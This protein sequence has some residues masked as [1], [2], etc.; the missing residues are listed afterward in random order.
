MIRDFLKHNWPRYLYGSIF[1]ILVDLLMLVT[2]RVIGMIVDEIRGGAQDLNLVG[3]LILAVIGVAFGLFI[4][5]LLWRIFIMG[6]A[7]RFEYYTR[8]TLFEKLLTLSP[9]FYDKTRVGDLMARFTNDVN[10]V[11]MAMGPAIVMIIDAVFLVT[12]TIIAMGLFTNWSL[13]WISIAPLPALAV[14]STFFGKMIHK[15]F[16]LVQ[17]SFSDLTDTIEESISGV[18]LIKSYG[19][20]DLRNETLTEKSNLYV[21]KNMNLVKVWGMFFPLTQTLSMLGSVLATLFGGRMVIL[22]QITLGEYITFTSYL[23]MLVWPMTAFGWVINIIQRGRASYRRLMEVL[24]E[25]NNITTNDPIEV[26]SFEGH[27]VMKN[28]TFTYPT[29]TRPALENIDFEVKPDSKIAIVGTTGSGKSTMAKL[30]AR[31]YPVEEGMLFIDGVDINNLRPEAIRDNVAYVPQETFLFSETV[32]NNIRFGNMEISDEEVERYAKVASIHEDIEGFSKGYKTIVGERGVTLSGGQKQ[33]ISIAR[34]L[35]KE[36]PLVILDD[37]L[38][39]VDTETEAEILKSLKESEINR[40]IIVISHRLKAVVDSD[41]I[42][43]LHDGRIVE[44]GAHADLV[45]AGGLYQRMYERQMLE[46]K[47]EEE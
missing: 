19:I 7:R 43:V 14:V 17:A 45:E 33:R 41:E 26:V 27:V 34:A 8:K 29:G 37:C 44:K 11:R 35:I 46:E 38:S 39:A 18:R 20:E 32:G 13:T 5:R 36:A 42:Y 4:T 21:D 16:K 2:P 10:A 24:E 22:G 30:I 3:L 6:A 1:L 40:S 15:R 9:T 28:L 12:V 23:G 31:L 47:L 25:E